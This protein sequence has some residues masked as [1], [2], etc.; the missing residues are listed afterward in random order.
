MVIFWSPESGGNFPWPA[1]LFNGCPNLPKSNAHLALAMIHCKY[2]PTNTWNPT[3][4][5][6]KKSGGS[7][8]Q[9]DPSQ[10]LCFHPL[11]HPVCSGLWNTYIGPQKKKNKNP[12]FSFF[13]IGQVPKKGNYIITDY[14]QV[15]LP[16]SLAHLFSYVWFSGVDVTIVWGGEHHW[17]QRILPKTISATPDG[18]HALN[19][20]SHE[21]QHSK[22]I[23]SAVSQKYQQQALGK[24]RTKN[25]KE[26]RY[27]IRGSVCQEKHAKGKNNLDF[28]FSDFFFFLKA[29]FISATNVN[30]SKIWWKFQS[31]HKTHS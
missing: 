18:W 6:D 20:N 9:A 26:E 4:Q 17:R 8:N 15:S 27:E 22:N 28:F 13:P 24:A 5:L 14:K 11:C 25:M 7:T 12:Q 31:I 19:K 2:T 16:F 23:M 3:N 10:S 30:V 21:A 29:I 1:A